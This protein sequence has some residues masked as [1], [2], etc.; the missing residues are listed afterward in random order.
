MKIVYNSYTTKRSK[1]TS[2]NVFTLQINA[3][4]SIFCNNG[5]ILIVFL[6]FAVAKSLVGQKLRKS[7]WPIKKRLDLRAMLSTTKEPAP[8]SKIS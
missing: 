8:L 3:T 5:T 7:N 6:L 4:N 1:K 2:Y